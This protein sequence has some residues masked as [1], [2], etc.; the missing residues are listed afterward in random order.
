M[1]N[2]KKKLI[3]LP[4]L[5]II[6]VNYRTPE[7]TIQ[8]VKSIAGEFERATDF[9]EG[10]I[11]VILVDNCSDDSDKAS[12]IGQSVAQLKKLEQEYDWCRLV[13]AK[14]NGGFATG[15]R[16][17][18]EKACGEIIFLLNSDTLVL[19]GSLVELVKI[20]ERR[21]SIWGK[22]A[23]LACQLRTSTSVGKSILQDQG[24]DLPSLGTL[25]VQMLGLDDLPVIGRF[26]PSTQKRMRF[27]TGQKAPQY[28]PSGWVGGT[29]LLIPQ[30]LINRV[31]FLDEAIFM[32]GEDV[33]FC[34]RV[35]NFWQDQKNIWDLEQKQKLT[36]EKE[37][38]AHDQLIKVSKKPHWPIDLQKPTAILNTVPIIHYGSAS[39]T[40]ARALIGEIKGYL[41]IWQKH[42]PA[43]QLPILKV[44]LSWGVFWRKCIFSLIPSKRS[45]VK[46]YKEAEKVIWP[47]KSKKKG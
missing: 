6:I 40:S 29:A 28:S 22:Y 11:E 36:R 32:Y 34:L 23:L 37:L 41:Y 5:S 13:V 14:K 18:Y 47:A 33:E 16:L 44:I 39:S 30:G 24:G 45:R 31:G 9:L 20:L 10:K 1:P 21:P 27:K 17:G 43:W 38:V 19:P 7:L 42:F 2:K 46:A 3:T 15:N 8:T 4:L 35:R 25:A 26:L 12:P